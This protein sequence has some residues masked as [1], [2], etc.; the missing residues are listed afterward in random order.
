MAIGA[1]NRDNCKSESDEENTALE[2]AQ[3][4]AFDGCEGTFA[5]DCSEIPVIAQAAVEEESV[6][7]EEEL[8]M[9][10]ESEDHASGLGEERIL[11]QAG[12]EDVRRLKAQNLFLHALD[13]MYERFKHFQVLRPVRRWHARAKGWA[14]DQGAAV[15]LNIY[16]LPALG[17]SL[18]LLGVFHSGI[19]VYGNEYAYGCNPRRPDG[20]GVWKCR[21]RQTQ[22]FKYKRTVFLGMTSA[23]EETVKVIVDRLYNCWIAGAYD[24]V[25]HNCNH[26]TEEFCQALLGKPIP[27]WVNRLARVAAQLGVNQASLTP[28]F[29]GQKEV[30]TLVTAFQ[31][32]IRIAVD[33][34][35]ARSAEMIEVMERL[36]EAKLQN[37]RLKMCQKCEAR[38][39]GGITK[40]SCALC[41]FCGHTG[42]WAACTVCRGQMCNS[43]GVCRV[44]GL[45]DLSMDSSLFGG[46]SL[47]PAGVAEM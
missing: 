41:L 16:T 24:V 17:G 21:P 32:E 22:G 10:L 23:R 37:L 7:A 28:K 33:A 11:K 43:C 14:V 9:R 4:P 15:M 46:D 27:P 2:D 6:T 1:M 5:S 3:L 38:E 20:T 40:D 36:C 34:E 35:R 13:F 30:D 12:A 39:F 19:E 25:C 26:F 8:A 45:Y 44:C 18:G 47:D 42:C 31:E 29:Q